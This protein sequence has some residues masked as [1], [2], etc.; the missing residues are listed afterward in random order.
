MSD[1]AVI[2]IMGIGAA[3]L[4]AA[5]GIWEAWQFVRSHWDDIFALLV[6]GIVIGVPVT[7]AIGKTL[8]RVG[9]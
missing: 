9:K 3:T 1:R 8:F 5:F 7:I 2:T 6:L 4:V